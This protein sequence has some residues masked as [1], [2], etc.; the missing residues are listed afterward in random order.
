MYVVRLLSH[1]QNLKLSVSLLQ[2]LYRITQKKKIL[3][4]GDVRENFFEI[5][6]NYVEPFKIQSTLAYN[7]SGIYRTQM[8]RP[9]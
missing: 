5:C 8:L 9:K 1:V 6:F 2:L 3:L 7:V 4:H